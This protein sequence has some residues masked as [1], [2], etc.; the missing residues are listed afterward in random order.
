MS[1]HFVVGNIALSFHAAAAAVVKVVLE[2]HGYVA[3]E[4]EAAH[5]DMFA[6]LAR[7]DV[8]L[9]VAAW[10]P[11]SHGKYFE[12][13]QTDVLRL[14]VLYRPY[15]IWGVPE[16]VPEDEVSSIEDLA[17]PEIARTFRTLVQGIGEG[18]GISR[19]S[20]AIIEQYGL[21]PLGFQFK[22][23]TLTD[24]VSAFE[25]AVSNRERCVVPLWHPQFLHH[26]HK[27]RA[28]KDPKRLLGDVDDAQAL[29]RKDAAKRL[30]K[31]SFDALAALTIGNAALARMDHAINREGKSPRDAAVEWLGDQQSKETK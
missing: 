28:L 24:C 10:L 2:E 16:Y 19:F 7:G 6:L 15:C 31:S 1:R 5:E 17:R 4:R 13:L 14:G 21:A 26:T 20:R 23:G 11:A 22:S 27:I 30:T 25:S 8:D 3:E 9:L 18:A 12:P 29:I